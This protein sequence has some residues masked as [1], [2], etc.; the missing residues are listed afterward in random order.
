[1]EKKPRAQI[2]QRRQLQEAFSCTLRASEDEEATTF[3]SKS[4]FN[5]AS[6]GNLRFS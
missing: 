5:E 6:K 3:T 4:T 2:N 1:M